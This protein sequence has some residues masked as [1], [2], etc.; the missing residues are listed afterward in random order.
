MAVLEH[1]ADAQLRGEVRAALA[2]A[3]RRRRR[4]ARARQLADAALVELRGA[5]E[6]AAAS[7]RALADWLAQQP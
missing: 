2:R 3:G 6:P 4:Q 7:A 5:G 1:D